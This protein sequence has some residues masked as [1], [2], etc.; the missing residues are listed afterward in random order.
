M[1]RKIDVSEIQSGT[2]QSKAFFPW[3]FEIH[4]IE[5][6]TI[7]LRLVRQQRAVRTTLAKGLIPVRHFASATPILLAPRKK[8]RLPGSLKVKARE[9]ITVNAT[10]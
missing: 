7:M 10:R 8:P 2:P 5:Y 4:Q 9:D 1:F 6:S 3:Q